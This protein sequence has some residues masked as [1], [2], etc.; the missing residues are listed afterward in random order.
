M[1]SL[2]PLLVVALASVSAYAEDAQSACSV[3]SI[4]SSIDGM[5]SVVTTPVLSEL[6]LKRLARYLSTNLRAQ[7]I[8]LCTPR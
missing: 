5:S 4:V 1:K 8:N 2:L 3:S 7:R 6:T